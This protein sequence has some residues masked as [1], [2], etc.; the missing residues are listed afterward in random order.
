MTPARRGGAFS[1][2]AL[3]SLGAAW[4]LRHWLGLW[5]AQ[6]SAGLAAGLCLLAVPDSLKE[7]QV[8]NARRELSLGLLVGLVLLLATE[9][10]VPPVLR[11]VPFL[12]RE[13]AALYALLASEPGALRAVPVLLTIVLL[14]EWALRGVVTTYSLRQLGPRVGMAVA[15]AATLI[16]MLFAPSWLLWA[17]ALGLGTSLLALRQLTGGLL[18]PLIAHAVWDLGVLVLWPLVVPR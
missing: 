17:L 5:P 1:L 10:L 9:L 6:A 3:L 15:L 7:F 14:E 11:Y 8:R 12:G 2:L 13:L 16:P 18:A 4:L